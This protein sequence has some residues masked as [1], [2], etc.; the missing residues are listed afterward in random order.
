MKPGKNNFRDKSLKFS[1]SSKLE[2]EAAKEWKKYLEKNRSIIVD[3]FQVFIENKFNENLK[4]QIKNTIECS[5]C[6]KALVNFEPIM[7]F[8]LPLPMD[9]ENLSLENCLKEFTQPEILSDGW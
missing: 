4:G 8:T 6:K 1:G 7:Y 2:I 3:L 5:K 9:K